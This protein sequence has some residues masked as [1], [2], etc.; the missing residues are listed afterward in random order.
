MFVY[1]FRD[2]KIFFTAGEIEIIHR[3]ANRIEPLNQPE[4]RQ[5]KL[6]NG[7]YMSKEDLNEGRDD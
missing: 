1:R 6:F 3:F 4:A 7:R 5:L 2:G